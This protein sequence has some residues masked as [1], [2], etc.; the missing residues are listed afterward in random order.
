MTMTPIADV[1][2]A[3]TTHIANNTLPKLP[4][5]LK[6]IPA[7]SSVP[8]PEFVMMPLLVAPK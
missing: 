1:K 3:K 7:N 5:T 8:L 4:I 6:A 2:Q